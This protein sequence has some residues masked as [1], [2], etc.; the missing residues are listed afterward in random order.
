MKNDTQCTA[1]IYAAP[2]F[3]AGL[4]PFTVDAG[5]RNDITMPEMNG[6]YPARW[7]QRGQ[8]H[9]LERSDASKRRVVDEVQ[10]TFTHALRMFHVGRWDK[11]KPRL[12]MRLLTRLV[13]PAEP[14][15]H[16]ADA[17]YKNDDDEID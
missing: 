14:A 3:P 7:W 4:F 5:P 2:G 8:P 10:I 15:A 17:R 6:N 1:A 13:Q 16:F 9:Q 12:A 11:A